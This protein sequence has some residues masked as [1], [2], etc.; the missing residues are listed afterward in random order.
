MLQERHLQAIFLDLWPVALQ[1][2]K[3]AQVVNDSG[4]EDLNKVLCGCHL[5]SGHI[6]LPDNEKGCVHTLNSDA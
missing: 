3:I 4:R 6:F 5:N 1:R 2:R